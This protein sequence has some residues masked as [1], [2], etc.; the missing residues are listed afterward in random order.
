MNNKKTSVTGCLIL[1]VAIFLI[2]IF[3][4]MFMQNSRD[5]PLATDSLS[6]ADA[7]E[8]CKAK[9]KAQ[10]PAGMVKVSNC[11]KRTA[12]DEFFYFS[13]KRPM[14]IFIRNSTGEQKAY[15]GTCQVSRKS[16]EIVHLT[17]NKKVLVNKAKK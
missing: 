15:S 16:G 13:W 1:F 4:S 10:R 6:W 2:A 14:S 7:A 5:Q 11:K 8:K 17:L 12:D 9:Y 3:S